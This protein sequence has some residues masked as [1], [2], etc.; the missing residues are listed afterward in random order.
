MCA[1]EWSGSDL[2]CVVNLILKIWGMLIR[3]RSMHKQIKGKPWISC[4]MLLDHILSFPLKWSLQYFDSWGLHFFCWGSPGKQLVIFCNVLSWW[5]YALAWQEWGQRGVKT[6]ALIPFFWSY[7]YNQRRGRCFYF[8]AL[9]FVVFHRSLSLSFP[10]KE[11]PRDWDQITGTYKREKNEE[12]L[13]SLS[14]LGVPASGLQDR[15][16]ELVSLAL[17][18]RAPLVSWQLHWKKPI[19]NYYI[20]YNSNSVRFCKRQNHEYSKKI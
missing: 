17:C 13:Y 9:A 4:M 16:R 3:I 5:D 2:L 7:G 10:E 11:F 1:P 19:Q 15:N 6:M 18:H 20:L 8:R 12:F 14:A